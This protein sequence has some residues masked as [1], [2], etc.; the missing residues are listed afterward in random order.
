[1]QGI[2]RARPAYL[3]LPILPIG[4]AFAYAECVIGRE[5]GDET[6]SI[7]RAST[8]MRDATAPNTDTLLFQRTYPSPTHADTTSRICSRRA[9]HPPRRAGH[10][11]MPFVV[12]GW[13]GAPNHMEPSSAAPFPGVAGGCSAHGGTGRIIHVMN[14]MVLVVHARTCSR[15]NVGTAKDGGR[16]AGSSSPPASL[17]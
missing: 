4:V 8:K 5:E 9:L 2:E 3:S 1:M 17:V 6:R 15:R 13:H 14:A 7:E 12:H 10:T 16:I 11:Y